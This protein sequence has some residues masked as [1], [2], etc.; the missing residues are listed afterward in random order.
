MVKLGDQEYKEERKWV[1][2]N[3]EYLEE[4]KKIIELSNSM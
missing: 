2:I 1:R 4:Q 3:K